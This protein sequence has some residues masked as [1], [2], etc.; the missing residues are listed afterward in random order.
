MVHRHQRVGVRQHRS[1]LS[2]SAVG[3]A[4]GLPGALPPGQVHDGVGTARSGGLQ[5][6]RDLGRP[7]APLHR[8]QAARLRRL[9]QL[10]RLL[11]VQHRDGPRPH[12]TPAQRLQPWQEGLLVPAKH[13]GQLVLIAPPW[14]L[15]GPAAG[16]P[17]RITIL[18]I[19]G[20]LGGIGHRARHLLDGLPGFHLRASEDDGAEAAGQWQRAGVDEQALLH[21]AAVALLQQPH[22]CHAA[23]RVGVQSAREGL[24]G[25]AVQL[26]GHR[27]AVQ[28]VA[29]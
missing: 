26:F 15:L 1:A 3:R 24:E 13:D 29:A 6:P 20:K 21:R 9:Q 5:P 7:R 28:L 11:W 25:H 19:A 12:L 18:I 16:S 2:R 10:L 14:L 27:D 17:S 22:G 8:P 23:G 4:A